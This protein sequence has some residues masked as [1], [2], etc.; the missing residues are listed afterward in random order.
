MEQES[1]LYFAE[2][3]LQNRSALDLVRSNFTFL[4][5][6]LAMHYGIPGVTG[7]QMRKVDT[8]GTLR[9]GALTQGSYHVASSSS[10]NTSIVLR[11]KWVLHNLLCTVIPTPPAGAAD[12]VPPPDPGLGLTNRQSLERRTANEPCISCHKVINPIG[13]GLE[14]FDGI[15][16]QRSTDKGQPID[17]SGEL[18]G[19]LK[20]KDTAELL[21]LLKNDERFPVC[22]TQKL[23]TYALGR[24]MEAPCDQEIIDTLAKEFKADGFKLKNHIVRIAKSELFRTARR[25][26]VQP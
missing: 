16:A 10:E 18:P 12:S 11:A 15:G 3:L 19:G 8:T 26:E 9:G 20:F 4:N 23:F 13:F 17:A 14:V 6:R 5:Q 25:A 24:G 21:E 1:L 2:V 22:L 7:T